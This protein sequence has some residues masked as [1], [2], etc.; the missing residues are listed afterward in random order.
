[1]RERGG[2]RLHGALKGGDAGGQLGD[3]GYGHEGLEVPRQLLHRLDQL[4][5]LRV[6]VPLHRPL[7]LICAPAAPKQVGAPLPAVALAS[8]SNWV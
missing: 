5:T 2:G 3:L 6:L 7:Q 4:R 8:G 1:M